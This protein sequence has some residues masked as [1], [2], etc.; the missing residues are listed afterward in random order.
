MAGAAVRLVPAPPAQAGPL[1]RLPP[2]DADSQALARLAWERR[3]RRRIFLAALF[4]V[5]V[6]ALALAAHGLWMNGFP[7]APLNLWM[8]VGVSCSAAVPIF[9]VL[10]A[11][12]W[13]RA[14]RAWLLLSLALAVGGVALAVL[15]RLM[16]GRGS[17]LAVFG[18]VGAFYELAANMLW[19]PLLLGLAIGARRARGVAPI[20]FA[21]L[22]VFGLGQVLAQRL[23]HW[24]GSTPLG[25]EW[26]LHGP[27]LDTGFVLI[28]LPIGLLAWQR[29]KALAHAYEAKTFSDA[30][31]LAGSWWLLMVVHHSVQLI[32]V[33]AGVA[34]LL[35]VLAVAGL[36]YAMFAPLLRWGL[37]HAYSTEPRPAPRLLLLLRVFGNTTRTEALFD[38]TALR[39]QLFGPV[40]MIAAP[41]VIA[42]TV[43]PGDILRFALG[44]LD[45]SFVNNAADLERRIATL[46]RAP[47]PTAVT[48]STSSAAAKAAGRPPLWR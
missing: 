46:D 37:Q 42:R 10:T 17:T 36:A 11:T 20:V 21:A 35:T 43:D 24:L 23:T 40:A 14:L 32:S 7:P 30:Q 1:T 25:T 34:K 2:S 16:D 45:A 13:W 6:P 38:R 19:A 22:L 5:A 44:H 4:A 26:L 8:A 9:A 3:L 28:A 29:L 41:D 12:P 48:G 31:L 18:I 15:L 47:T 39:W 27:G 33:H